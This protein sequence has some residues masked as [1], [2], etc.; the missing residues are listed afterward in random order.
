MYGVTV[1][2]YIGCLLYRVTRLLC[3]DAIYRMHWSLSHITVCG[4]YTILWNYQPNQFETEALLQ[5]TVTD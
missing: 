2:K 5:L 4:M 1:D 3:R